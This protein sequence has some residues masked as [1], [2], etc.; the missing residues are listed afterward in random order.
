MKIGEADRIQEQKMARAPLGTQERNRTANRILD[1]VGRIAGAGGLEF[2][3]DP[4][5][6]AQFAALKPPPRSR[7]SG[8]KKAAPSPSVGG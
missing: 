5:V 8:A 3:H 1:A 7:K 6:R 4:E 2:A